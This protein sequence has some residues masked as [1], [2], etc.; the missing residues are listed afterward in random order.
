[1][2]WLGIRGRR[3]RVPGLRSSRVRRHELEDQFNLGLDP[4][5]GRL[6]R[7]GTGYLGVGDNGT[8]FSSA[9]G[10]LWSHSLAPTSSDLLGLASD[11]TTTVAVGSRGAILTTADG[12]SWQPRTA[13]N[14]NSLGDVAFDGTQFVAF[15]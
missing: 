6:T 15:G 7:T 14:R 3:G 13:G 12:A 10:Q 1:V 9:D 5:I 2:G 4:P 8:L 11:G